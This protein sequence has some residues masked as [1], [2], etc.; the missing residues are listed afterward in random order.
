MISVDYTFLALYPI[1]ALTEERQYLLWSNLWVKLMFKNYLNKTY[2]M[3]RVFAN[4]PGDL[5]SIPS[6]VIPKTQKVVLDTILLNTQQYKVRIKG[7]AE[8]SREGIA[9]SPT[10]RCSSYCKGSLL[11]ALNYGRQLYNFTYLNI[12]FEMQMGL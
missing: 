3:G 5:G 9:P 8:Q 10:S 2:L 12:S 7:K 4:G 11:A 1:S 6:R